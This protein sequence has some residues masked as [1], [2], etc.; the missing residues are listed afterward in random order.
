MSDF[1]DSDGIDRKGSPMMPR[2]VFDDRHACDVTEAYM[3]L[4]AEA[5]RQAGYPAVDAGEAAPSRR[6][7]M[8]TDEVLV[9][10]RYRL[11]GYRRHVVWIQGL[12]PE[13]SYMRHRSRLRRFVLSRIEKYVLRR[14]ELLLF[15][16]QEML[17]HYERK[18]RLPLGSKSFVMPCFCE[19]EPYIPAQNAKKDKGSFAYIGS[20]AAWQCFSQTAAFYAE[21]ERRAKYPTKFIVLTEDTQRAAAILAESGAVRYEVKC[22]RGEVLARA[23]LPIRYGFVL[24]EED[25]VN[26][27]ATPTKLS[28]YAAC[29]IVPIYSPVLA[30]FSLRAARKG[31]GIPVSLPA[32]EEDIETVL[33]D[34]EKTQP[35]AASGRFLFDDYY[36]ADGYRDRLAEL[37][38]ERFAEAPKKRRVLI[39]VGHLRTGGIA[40]ALY[41]LLAEIHT[42]YDITL[43][44]ADG[45]VE[46]DRIPSD[47]SVFPSDELLRATETPRCRLRELSLPAK[48]FRITGAAFAKLFGKRI[49]FSFLCRRIK[50]RLPDFDAAVS[51]SQPSPVRSFCNISCELAL[52]GC[53]A[54]RR[55]AFLHC[56]FEKYGANTAGNRRLYRK[57]DRVC[58]V[59]EGAAASFL[60]CMPQMRERL[61]VVPNILDGRRILSLAA[62]GEDCFPNARHPIILSVA[63]LSPEKGH[64][65]CIPLMRRLREAGFLFE[66]HIVGTG[67]CERAIA[68]AISKNHL[69]DTVFLH[70]E[71]KNPYRYMAQADFLFHPSFHEAAPLV[72]SE[73]VL[74]SLPVLATETSSAGELL[75]E[76][77]ILCT[78]G[79]D[80]LYHALEKFLSQRS[81][82]RLCRAEETEMRLSRL[83]GRTEASVRAF[84][85][86]VEGAL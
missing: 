43:I 11:L 82:E 18:Y 24:R 68:D 39:T 71:T 6:D 10:L 31:Y 16:S 56:D 57:F 22:L 42:L 9:A 63:R 34:M 32:K 49:P 67:P 2:F 55:I 20:L 37:L 51:F 48:L 58:A 66:W 19:R 79:D 77:G 41:A 30:D 15:V 53:R 72:F 17:L 78:A 81:Y 52:F 12:V 36:Y 46:R 60:R 4:L 84:R 5:V 35:E 64:L 25:P 38:R 74:L 65:R 61:A 70:G 83:A 59:S 29:G 80:A 50:R 8:V 1:D 44:A 76:N 27:V 86:A 47:V 21:I 73:A 26:R 7:V 45:R 23:L 62:S 75:G 40:N 54:A 14:A 85:M 33:R 13:E 69:S 3:H 28:V